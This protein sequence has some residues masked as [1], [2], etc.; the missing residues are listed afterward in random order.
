MIK[1]KLKRNVWVILLLLFIFG[2]VFYC[3]LFTKLI[4]LI[5]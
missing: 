5:L 4:G 2:I 1:N 3:Y